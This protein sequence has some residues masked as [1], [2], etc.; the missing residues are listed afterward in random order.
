M[1][2]RRI[3]LI[4]LVI[5]AA[6]VLPGCVQREIVVNPTAAV[7]DMAIKDD[8]EIDWDQVMSDC[9]EILN[10]DDYPMGAYLDFAIHEAT[11]E[12]PAYTEIIWPV[13]EEITEEQAVEYAAAYAR[14]FN[15]AV[16]TQ[17]FSYG[18]SSD[19]SYGEYWDKNNMYV[20]VFRESDILFPEH[21]LVNQYIEA[22]SND[23][24]IT[25]TDANAQSLN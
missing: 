23:P 4:G 22:G 21:Y 12:Q 17:D 5:A 19:E 9:E 10:E 3:A 16:A 8:V 7:P 18:L 24:I 25:S 1:T 20:Q 14:A 15:D 2:F 13:K 11:D 6:A